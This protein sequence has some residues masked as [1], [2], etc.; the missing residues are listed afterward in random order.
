MFHNQYVINTNESRIHSALIRPRITTTLLLEEHYIDIISDPSLKV[1][2]PRKSKAE[3]WLVIE[4][5]FPHLSRKILNVFLLLAKSY[6]N[7]TGISDLAAIKT[8]C[9]YMMNL[10]NDHRAAI[11]K[12]KPHY[13]KLC[14][15]QPHPS[16]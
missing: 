16:H 11:S 13:D 9:R 2:F 8:R 5:E 7:E 10:E 6:V 4:G 12:L 14:S 15:R 1:R 3:F